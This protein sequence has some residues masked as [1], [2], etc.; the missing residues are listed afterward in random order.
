MF[1]AAITGKKKKVIYVPPPPIPLHERRHKSK[2]INQLPYAPPFRGGI[3]REE[4]R[5]RE[6]A[7]LQE[8]KSPGGNVGVTS[9]KRN[10]RCGLID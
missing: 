3:A 5:K 9:H 7:R 10:V 8:K 6:E 2:L 1:P 4:K